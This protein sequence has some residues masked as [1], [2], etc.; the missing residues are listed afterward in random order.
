MDAPPVGAGWVH[1]IKWDG[2]RFSAYVDAGTATIRT[3]NGYDWTT[4]FPAVAA[5]LAALKLRSA[6][7]DG[8]AVVL[9]EQGRS[10]F[11]ALQTDLERHT[12][13]R[14]VMYAFDLLHLDGEDLRAKP[15]G[16]RRATLATLIP[17]RSALLMSDEYAGAGA[18]LFMR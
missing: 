4:R 3:R 1:E 15:L 10:S 14:A 16:E 7:I 9:D 2:Y 5:A 11:A 18:D 8:E 6:V 13:A 12:A 17:K